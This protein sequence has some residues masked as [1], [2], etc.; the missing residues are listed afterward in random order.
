M[1]TGENEV[2]WNEKAEIRKEE[3]L[4]VGE[5]GKN[6]FWYN[7]G[8]KGR[9]FYS[10]GFSAVGSLI[11]AAGVSH[12]SV[13]FISVVNTVSTLYNQHQAIR[14]QSSTRVGWINNQDN[15]LSA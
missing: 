3:L 13:P 15:H 1:R 9:I 11:Y 6:I 10:S 14:D 2:K 8:L 5:E 7:P 4:A 12:C